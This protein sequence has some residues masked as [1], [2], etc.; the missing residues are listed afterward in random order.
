METV[1]VHWPEPEA[2]LAAGGVRCLGSN[3]RRSVSPNPPLV[4]Q[5][6]GR[7]PTF[8]ASRSCYSDHLVGGGQV[9][10]PASSAQD[11]SSSRSNLPV[12]VAVQVKLV[13]LSSADLFPES[14][15]SPSMKVS[16]AST[17]DECRRFGP[18]RLAGLRR[19]RYRRSDHNIPRPLAARI[20]LPHFS[21]YATMY[22]Q[23]G[24]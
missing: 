13:A 9:L 18:I 23:N 4:T 15:Q 20:T 19:S 24:R 11:P 1:L 3:C 17:T 22:F 21:F 10:G 12:P 5:N 2:T 14:Q 16:L 7:Q 8:V 6:G